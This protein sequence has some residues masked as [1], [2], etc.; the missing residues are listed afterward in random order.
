MRLAIIPT[1]STGL[2]EQTHIAPKGYVLVDFWW[3]MNMHSKSLQPELEHHRVKSFFPRTN[4][5][6]YV[7]QIAKLERKEHLMQ[8][9]ASD[10][11]ERYGSSRSPGVP[12][13]RASPTVHHHIA[14]Q[15]TAS[16]NLYEW[17]YSNER[18][19]DPAL[20]VCKLLMQRESTTDVC[21]KLYS[22]TQGPHPY[23]LAP[24]GHPSH[25]LILQ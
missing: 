19:N 2:V 13:E 6:H 12:N 3:K 16:V 25:P 14:A 1:Q 24:H 10:L 21:A 11:Q 8:K 5:N 4:K 23:P 17:L 18:R 22:K 7:R 15:S 20:K 9:F